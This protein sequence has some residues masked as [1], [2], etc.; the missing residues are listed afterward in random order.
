ML[1]STYCN[2]SDGGFHQT[3]A[4]H[5]VC[6][7]L[8]NDL[9]PACTLTAVSGLQV[10]RQKANGSS[11][12]QAGFGSPV[13]SN[14]NAT[15]GLAAAPPSLPGSAAPSLPV[16]APLS[17]SDLNSRYT[18]RPDTLGAV[19]SCASPAGAVPP[20][21]SSGGRP[22]L[23][24]RLAVGSPIGSISEAPTPGRHPLFAKSHLG[25]LLGFALYLSHPVCG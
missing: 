25:L 12:S 4:D 17:L 21:R 19:S 2:C 22:L 24:S 14:A 16:P 3:S 15:P 20:S 7:G 1:A 9:C 8:V 6:H 10:S 13:D 18:S 5:C 11:I 23:P